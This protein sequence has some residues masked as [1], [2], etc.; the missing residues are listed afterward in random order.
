MITGCVLG[1]AVSVVALTV[2]LPF[3]TPIIVAVVLAAATQPVVTWMTRHGAARTLAAAAGTLLVPVLMV[4]L[5]WIVT[6]SLSGQ[7]GKW[8]QI[9]ATAAQR[10]RSATGVDP[11]TPL[12]DAS[13]RRGILLGLSS[14]LIQG[15]AAVAEVALGVV[16]AL[17]VL[18][19][20]LKDGPRFTTFLIG[21]L[22]L[23]PATTSDML[24][25]AAFRLRRYFVGTA[26]VGAMDAAAISLGALI[27]RVPLVLVIALVTFAAAFIPYLGAFL[28]G[29]F[30]VVIALGSGGVPT[31]LWMLALVL[32]TQNVFDA[33]LRPFAFGVALDMHPLAVLAATVAGAVLGGV[34]GVFVAPPFAAIAVVW[35][36]LMRQGP[37]GTRRTR[38]HNEDVNG[39]LPAPASAA[40]RSPLTDG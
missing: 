21:R 26:V 15:V 22:P 5:G 40:D 32:L 17:Y 10:L 16:L 23:P 14:V 7:G 34:I 6:V 27:L 30:A 36:R 24:A 37:G 3:I 38:R 33:L 29:A 2:L 39:G 9:G 13:Q 1:A 8:Q 4:A 31:A 18:F 11:L 19:F 28:S 25:G 12:L 20:L 35:L